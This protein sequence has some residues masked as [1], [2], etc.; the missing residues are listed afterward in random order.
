MLKE[1]QKLLEIEYFVTCD[2]SKPS[3][4]PTWLS[5]T[6]NDC[7]D[8]MS[9]ATSVEFSLNSRAAGAPVP[10]SSGFQ[11]PRAELQHQHTLCYHEWPQVACGACHFPPA[12]LVSIWPSPKALFGERKSL[13]P[14]HP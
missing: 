9:A 10:N 13:S 1:T 5:V 8:R 14:F 4:T 12:A 3:E 6:C 2:P 7:E 11:H